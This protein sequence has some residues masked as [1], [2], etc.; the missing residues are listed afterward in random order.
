MEVVTHYYASFVVVEIRYDA[1]LVLTHKFRND[2]VTAGISSGALQRLGP[3]S[4]FRLN[5][6]IKAKFQCS[7]KL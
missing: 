1:N 3:D 7:P 2:S 4:R 6:E 5:S